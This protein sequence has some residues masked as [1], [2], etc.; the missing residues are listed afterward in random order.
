V[1][2]VRQ[3]VW[4]P[5]ADAGMP[6]TDWPTVLGVIESLLPVAG[7]AVLTLFREQLAESIDH[8]L[9]EKLALADEN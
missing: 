9:G 1:D 5:F 6:E 2:R 7:Q 8:A 4:Q 3:E